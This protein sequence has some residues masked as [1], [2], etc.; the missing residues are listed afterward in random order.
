MEALQQQLGDCHA[1]V[2]GLEA[3]LVFLHVVAVLDGADDAGVGGRAADAVLFQFLHQRGFVE[4]RGGLGELLV[5]VELVQL[6]GLA[7]LEGGQLGVVLV[8]FVGPLGGVRDGLGLDLGLVRA[9]DR[10]PAGEALDLALGLEQGR[11]LAHLGFGLDHRLIEARGLHLT[12][13]GAPPDEGVEPELIGIQE[14]PQAFR[15]AGDVRGTDGLVRVLGPGLAGVDA[16]LGGQELLAVLLGDELAGGLHGLG[17]H[18]GRIRSHVGDE[19]H[20]AFAEVGA[21]IEPLG[22]LHGA[23]DAHLELLG[24]FLLQ[25]GGGEGRG[26]VAL[27]LLGFQARD[28]VVSLFE[29]GLQVLGLLLVGHPALGFLVAQLQGLATQ[30]H[31]LHP[32]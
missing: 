22:V 21:F 16:G 24:R 9:I 5:R 30:L 23:A 27:L 15:R 32:E 4:A 25:L 14:A 3:A 17:G 20:G 1:Q 19:A 12:G 10:Q 6:Q 2:R 7:Q 28:L 29:L 31:Q 13:H 18:A 8:L 11:V 26:G